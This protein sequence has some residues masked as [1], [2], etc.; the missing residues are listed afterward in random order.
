MIKKCHACEQP[1]NFGRYQIYMTPPLM[2]QHYTDYNSRWYIPLDEC[3]TNKVLRVIN[4]IL[5]KIRGYNPNGY[6]GY[7]RHTGENI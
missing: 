5:A 1:I 3:P 6:H 4:Y 7:S 2:W